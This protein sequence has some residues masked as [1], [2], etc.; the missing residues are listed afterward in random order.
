MHLQKHYCKEHCLF[1]CCLCIGNST[2]KNICSTFFSLVERARMFH[3]VDWKIFISALN[4]L[5]CPLDD[6][7]NVFPWICTEL[8]WSCCVIFNSVQCFLCNCLS[9]LFTTRRLS[10]C[11][12]YGKWHLHHP[13]FQKSTFV[14]ENI[15][16]ECLFSDDYHASFSQINRN[17]SAW[18]FVSRIKFTWILSKVLRF[19]ICAKIAIFFVFTTFAFAEFCF[20]TPV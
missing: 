11:G 6:I 2:K 16:K 18:I 4:S 3:A 7:V 5:A 1:F 14:T 8:V 20:L 13:V 9:F 19:T 15:E 10:V 12:A 17:P